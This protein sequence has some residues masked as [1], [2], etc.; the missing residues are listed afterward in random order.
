MNGQLVG[1]LVRGKFIP[2]ENVYKV[3][4]IEPLI[5]A[6]PPSSVINLHTKSG[7]FSAPIVPS[8][9]GH[10]TDKLAAGR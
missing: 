7:Q 3:V 6:Q 5:I 9:P 10:F 4:G 2:G 1:F 8:Q